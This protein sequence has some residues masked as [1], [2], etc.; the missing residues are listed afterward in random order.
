GAQEAG[1]PA[2]GIQDQRPR[3]ALAIAQGLADGELSA[4][5]LLHC[6]PL[7]DLPRAE[8]WREALARAGT[9]VAH[10]AFLTEGI[11][12][13]AD[14]VFPAESYAEKEGTVVH[15]DGRLQRLR[16]AIARPGAVRA[17]WQVL[18]ELASRVGL[19]VGVD[20]GA[21]ASRALFRAVAFY[22]DLTLEEIGGRGVRWQ[23]RAPAV[24][25]PAPSAEGGWL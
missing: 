9:V 1:T 10:A 14:V 20:T 3:D 24:A 4:L 19:D 6:D 11:R 7:R 8:L 25:F 13:H 18:A 23:E 21:A 16:P 2:G 22:R 15:P 12:E 17:G 5:Y